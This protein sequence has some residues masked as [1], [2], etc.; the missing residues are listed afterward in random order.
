[1]G[2]LKF[3]GCNAIDDDDHK[4]C[5]A[6]LLKT[7]AGCELASGIT[8]GMPA[9]R[10]VGWLKGAFMGASLVVWLL[11]GVWSGFMCL[12]GVCFQFVA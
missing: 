1:M 8:I 5:Y 12:V 7:F 3:P 11:S 6:F 4:T 10:G 2:D 9:D